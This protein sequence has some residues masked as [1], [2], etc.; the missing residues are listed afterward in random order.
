M[1]KD[2]IQMVETV[3]QTLIYATTNQ[4]KLTSMRSMLS[5]LP[6]T[7]ISLEE[8]KREW[9]EIQENGADPLANAVIK[10]TAYYE[11]VKRPLFSCDSGLF[12]DGLPDERQ[13][14]THVRQI[15]GRRLDDAEMINYYAQLAHELGG[16]A[17]ARYRNGLCLVLSP[18]QIFTHSGDDISYEP[19]YLTD[20]P[21]PQRR[22]GFPLDSLSIH[23]RTGR[24]YYD[25]GGADTLDLQ[26]AEGFRQFFLR[27][28]SISPSHKC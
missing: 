15:N 28:L 3:Q 14:G 20:K 26:T 27:T 18:T 4:A 22:P 24:Y 5:G 2:L 25:L 13:P 23:M 1:R 21:H 19:F 6:L 7:I 16:Q 10:A 17:R 12:I 9:P 8:I 11:I